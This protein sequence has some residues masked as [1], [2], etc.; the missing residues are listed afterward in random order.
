M[1]INVKIGDLNNTQSDLLLL[2]VFQNETKFLS[3][4]V[5]VNQ[6]L[7]GYIKFLIDNHEVTGNYL[8]LRY[9]I[10]QENFILKLNPKKF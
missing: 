6:S 8:K 3:S 9:F 1:N 5:L 7:D 4:T 10:L 2:G